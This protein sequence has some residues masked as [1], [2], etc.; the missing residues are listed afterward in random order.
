MNEELKLLATRFVEKNIGAF[1]QARIESLAKLQLKEI[2][3]RKNPY[4]FRAKNIF[5]SEQLV[6]AF[7]EARLSS[8]EETIFGDFLENLAIHINSHV[9]GGKKSSAVG[10][11]LEF[12]KDG[13]KYIVA[14]KSGPNWGNSSQITKMKENFRTAKRVLG[15]SKGTTNVVSV[16]GCCYGKDNVPEK[17]EYLK[18]CGQR[19]W[20][21]IAGDKN[22]YTDIIEPLG[23]KAKERNEEFNEQYGILLNTL[24]HEFTSEFCEAGR[25]NWTKLVKFNSEK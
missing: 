23:Y 2:L 20:E 10:I 5:T 13:K 14:I 3:Q 7:M 17:E 11:D 12:E 21:F 16:N 24:T 4:L 25:I 18:L 8:Q 1:H 15:T 6:H 19:F 22:L 9:Y